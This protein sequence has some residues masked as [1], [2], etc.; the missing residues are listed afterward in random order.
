MVLKRDK[1]SKKGDNGRVLVIAGS[2]DYPGAAFLAA[3]AVAAMRTGIDTVVVA[4]PE[5][6][7]WVINSLSPDII[8]RKLKGSCLEMGHLRQIQVLIDRC[9]VFLIGNG[10]GLRKKTM[11]LVRQLVRKNSQKAKVIDADAIKALRLQDIDNAIITPHKEEY[12]ILLENSRLSE[13]NYR[14]HLGSNVLLRKGHADRIISENKVKVN[15]TGSP[16]M[17]V[18]G[19][20]DVLA[21]LCAGYAALGLSLFDAAYYAARVNGLIGEGLEKYL[22]YGFIA[23]DFLGEIS[24]K[25]K[26]LYNM[27]GRI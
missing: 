22:G 17:T 18:A 19:T 5:K 7:A 15:R 16:G 21:G 13:K 8:T 23:S 4:A 9:D 1:S 24:R 6:V 3:G 2:V 12:R 20:G 14:K 10:I 26:D 25:S 11:E 27:T